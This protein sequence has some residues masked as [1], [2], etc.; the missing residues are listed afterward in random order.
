MGIKFTKTSV[1]RCGISTRRNKIVISCHK[2]DGDIS[3]SYRYRKQIYDIIKLIKD[4]NCTDSEG[5]NSRLDH[6][7][8]KY[9]RL[10]LLYK[11]NYPNKIL[12][13]YS[14]YILEEDFDD[15]IELLKGIEVD[16]KVSLNTKDLCNY[17]LSQLKTILTSMKR[18]KKVNGEKDNYF[19]NLEV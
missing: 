17:N 18:R 4:N 12:R 7:G 9:H 8:R 3:F 10:S 19:I 2:N 14:N 5:Y 6:C 13:F 11:E 1:G 15:I 16:N